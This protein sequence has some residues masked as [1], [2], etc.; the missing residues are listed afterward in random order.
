MPTVGKPSRMAG[1][2]VNLQTPKFGGSW[3]TCAFYVT[4]GLSYVMNG[5]TGRRPGLVGTLDCLRI[6]CAY[7]SNCV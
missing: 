6:G 1:A 3:Q 5:G 2:I 4:K 7:G